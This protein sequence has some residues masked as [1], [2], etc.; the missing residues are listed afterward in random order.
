MLVKIS[1][2]PTLVMSI[3]ATIMFKVNMASEYILDYFV[4]FALGILI[5]I[6]TIMNMLLMYYIIQLFPCQY[7]I[8]AGPPFAGKEINPRKCAAGRARGC[9][10]SG[11][12]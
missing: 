3:G 6:N 11:R 4:V 7:G 1:I 2:L 12:R 10:T 9:S 8:R 5:C